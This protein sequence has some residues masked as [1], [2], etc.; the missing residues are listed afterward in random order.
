MSV[1]LPPGPGE[2]PRKYEETTTKG[3]RV[4]LSCGHV[5]V[6]LVPGR[7][8][9]SALSLPVLRAP[10]NRRRFIASVQHADVGER[11][12]AC[13]RL[14]RSTGGDGRAG[15][16]PRRPAAKA[17]SRSAGAARVVAAV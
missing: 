2:T 10:A 13:A 4:R 7:G 8:H 16:R 14:V 15:S 12:R 6:P 11:P 17:R 1:T 9:R 3:G 5:R